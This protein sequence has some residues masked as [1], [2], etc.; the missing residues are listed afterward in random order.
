MPESSLNPQRLKSNCYHSDY[1]LEWIENIKYGLKKNLF[2]LYA[3]PIAPISG[4]NLKQHFEILL[5]LKDRNNNIVS[6][7]SFMEIAERN[8]LMPSIDTWVINNLFDKL[9]SRGSNLYWQ[10]YQFSVNLSGASLNSD[11][12]LDFVVQKLTNSNLSPQLFCFEMFVYS[13]C[14]A[15]F[16]KVHFQQEGNGS[17]S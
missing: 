14:V 6:P 1:E 5:R 13:I 16:I 3:Q 11:F 7:N 17:S 10:N 9:A 8:S 4:N 12:F 15:Y 2:L